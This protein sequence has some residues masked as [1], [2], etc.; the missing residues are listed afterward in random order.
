MLAV[1][2][3]T[4][5]QLLVTLLTQTHLAAMPTQCSWDPIN[6]AYRFEDKYCIQPEGAFGGNGIYADHQYE[7][8]LMGSGR[9]NGPGSGNGGHGGAL[10]GG[11]GGS[12]GSSQ[13]GSGGIGGGGGGGSNRYSPNNAFGFGGNGGPGYVLIEW[14]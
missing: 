5:I 9:A 12:Y 14:E 8:L 1:A 4:R 13:G 6:L 11:G 10:G 3:L 2:V 7:C